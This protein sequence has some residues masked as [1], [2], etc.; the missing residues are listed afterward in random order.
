[1]SDARI[2][3]YHLNLANFDFFL[4]LNARERQRE[5]DRERENTNNI[6]TV[7]LSVFV[8]EL[9]SMFVEVRY[10]VISPAVWL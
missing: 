8:G 6:N 7:D 3:Q 5:R 10:I 9:E 4:S 2:F 1:L